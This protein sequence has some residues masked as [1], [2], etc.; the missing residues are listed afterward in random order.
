[1]IKLISAAL[2]KQYCLINL[3]VTTLEDSKVVATCDILS[4][5]VTIYHKI[6][7]PYINSCGFELSFV[8]TI[9]FYYIGHEICTTR[10]IKY[11]STV[12]TC[13]YAKRY[14]KYGDIKYSHNPPF[15][16]TERR[17]GFVYAPIS[18]LDLYYCAAVEYRLCPCDRGGDRAV[19]RSGERGP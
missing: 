8:A 14:T 1:M 11:C 17:D 4:P 3:R 9:A 2:N 19:R 16:L 18:F 15:L 6:C 10:G 7:R 5:R 12:S 13:W